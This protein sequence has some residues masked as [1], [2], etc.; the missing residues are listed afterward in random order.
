MCKVSVIVPVYNT[1]LYLRRCLDSLAN[2]TIDSIEI[3]LVNDGSTDNS[4]SIMEEYKEKYPDKFTI[5][6]KENGGQATARNLGIKS[7]KGQYIGFVDS[8]DCVD[9]NMF[10]TMYEKAINN[11]CDY[12]ECHYHYIEEG[13]KGNKELQTRGNIRPYLGRKDMFINPQVSPWNKLYKREVLVD[14][15]ID[16]PEGL[17]YEDTAFFI[18]S[19][20]FI[21]QSAYIDSKF[22]NYY[23]RKTSTMNAN[24]SRKV[25]D[26]FKVIEDY[27]KFYKDRGLYEEYKTELEYFSSKII[28][29]SSLSR[30]GRVSDKEIRNQLLDESFE[31]L[32]KWFP[33]YKSNKYYG[34]KIGLYIKFVNRKNSSIIASVLGKVM[35]G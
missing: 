30:I 8:D 20:P 23:L 15:Q 5:I 21:K 11:K 2:Q 25:G 22:V 31:L 4:L 10:K 19:V 13:I 27:L 35:K 26:I 33:N 18:K 7:C 24:K 9:V 16:F 12:V 29:C 34:G 1:K 28:L 32:C 6:N 17:I 3:V 14:N